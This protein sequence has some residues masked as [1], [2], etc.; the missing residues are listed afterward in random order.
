MGTLLKVVGVVWAIIGGGNLAGMPWAESSQG[1][2]MFGLMF[3]MLLFIIP[4]LIVYG[5]G[6]G[7]KKKQNKATEQVE[8]SSKSESNIESRLIQL[9][10][11]K[12]KNIINESEYDARRS[13]ILKDI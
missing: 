11:L 3:N 1:V 6:F 5:I 10:N 2:L 12:E 4:G 7:I 13:E 8:N 9:S